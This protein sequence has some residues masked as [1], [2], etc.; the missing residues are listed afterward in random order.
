ME[1]GFKPPSTVMT[2]GVVITDRRT[3]ALSTL[4]RTAA[5]KYSTK[6]WSKNGS[7]NLN[8]LGSFKNTYNVR[9]DV[10]FQQALIYFANINL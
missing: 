4:K 1:F 3:M 5:L 7:G 8:K 6:Y 9:I 2:I 10:D